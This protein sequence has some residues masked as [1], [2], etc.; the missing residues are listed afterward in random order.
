M[1][2]SEIKACRLCDGTKLALVASLGEQCVSG[3]FLACK[4]VLPEVP[5]TVVRCLGCGLV[6]L[7]HSVPAELM[8]KKYWYRSG[9]N[10][11]MRDHLKGIV[12]EAKGRVELKPGDMVLDIGCNDG[13]LL[14]AY[15]I[16]PGPDTVQMMGMDPSNMVQLALEKGLPVVCDYFSAESYGR[17]TS[18]KAKII[19]SIAMFYDLED[20]NRFVADIKKILHPDGV[21]VLEMS[22][23]PTMLERNSFDTICHE[24]LEYYHLEP[25]ELLF[26][27]NKLYVMDVT[28]N[29][30]NGGSFRLTVKHADVPTDDE[31]EGYERISR[32]RAEEMM[33]ALDTDGPYMNFRRNI[34]KIKGDVRMFLGGVKEAG[35]VV[36]GYG[37][38]TKGNTILQF[39]DIT[40]E[41][42]P[43]I[44]DR[45]ESKWGHYTVGTNIPIISESESRAQKPDYYLVLPWHF[46]AEFRMRETEFLARGGRFVVPM[47]RLQVVGPETEVRSQKSEFCG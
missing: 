17:M 3:A 12:D 22:Y 47:P 10:Q 15:G 34:E 18:Q 4:S 9:V 42:L 24:H 5:L 45:N 19:T 44:A 26:A 43:C 39:C 46:M 21:W 36:H 33:L 32:M 31:D 20:P 28:K 30:M 7:Q 41:L 2:V 16:R 6:Q 25:L 38:S 29:E 1:N 23:L 27:A 37:A 14:E 13:T 40:P 35:K 11:T 8:Y